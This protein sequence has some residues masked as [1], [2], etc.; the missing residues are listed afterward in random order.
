MKLI[1]DGSIQARIDSHNRVLL[2]QVQG[3]A[4]RRLQAAGRP[5]AK[6]ITKFA[7]IFCPSLYLRCLARVD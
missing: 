1:L 5:A 4:A 3:P 6:A 7:A 2:A